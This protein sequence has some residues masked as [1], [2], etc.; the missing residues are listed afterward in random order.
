MDTKFQAIPWAA[1]TDLRGIRSWRLFGWSFHNVPVPTTNDLAEECARYSATVRNQL[2]GGAGDGTCF[3]ALE[4][5]DGR[6]Y[7]IVY[8]YSQL[9][10]EWLTPYTTGAG[11]Q[12]HHTKGHAEI[13][14]FINFFQGP[15][16]I[17]QIT[18]IYVE[19]S[20]CDHCADQLVNVLGGHARNVLLAYSYKYPEEVADWSR[21][22]KIDRRFAAGDTEYKIRK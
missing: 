9:S 3:A 4:Y 7:K 2:G 11:K 22:N 1:A 16:E 13:A 5:I 6:E 20:P 17:S 12:T 19:L 21:A 8:G 18:R 14:A 15:R 10:L